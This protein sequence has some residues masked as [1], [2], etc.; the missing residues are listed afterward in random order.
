MRSL[1]QCQAV[2]SHLVTERN[3]GCQ[4]LV[5]QFLRPPWWQL[6]WRKAHTSDLQKQLTDFERSPYG[7]DHGI[8]HFLQFASSAKKSKV[9][10]ESC[11]QKIR[12]LCDM[13]PSGR[14][15]DQGPACGPEI[16][17]IITP[18]RELRWLSI[19]I[20]PDLRQS[21]LGNVRVEH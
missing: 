13:A 20:H 11:T 7:L 19:P 5:M 16:G 18:L 3:T 14:S 15:G 2:F 10:R 1:A 12:P 17:C 8:G 6:P 4:Q 21:P 9:S